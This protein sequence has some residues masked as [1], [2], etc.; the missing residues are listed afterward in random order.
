MPWLTHDQFPVS[1]DPFTVRDQWLAD[2]WLFQIIQGPQ[3]TVDPDMS[4]NHCWLLRQDIL[5]GPWYP[6]SGFLSSN[7]DAFNRHVNY[8]QVRPTQV[9][10]GNDYKVA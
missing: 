3:C 10:L 9:P 7:P 2:F 8:E 6:P 1:H 4:K 5:S